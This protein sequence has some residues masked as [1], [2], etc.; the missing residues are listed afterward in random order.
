MSKLMTHDQ[1]A[2]LYKYLA[3]PMGC[4]FE[5]APE[6][7]D[8]ITWDCDETLTLTREWLEHHH[9]DVEANVA[10]L[11]ACGGW[12]DCEVVFNVRSRWENYLREHRE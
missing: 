1:F 3:G 5:D 12:C 4:N 9:L 6:E 10:A 11:Q 7:P 2:Q 8:G